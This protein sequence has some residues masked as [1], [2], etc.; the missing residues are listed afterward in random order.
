MLW[1]LA[2][3]HLIGAIIIHIV[4]KRGVFILELFLVGSYTPHNRVLDL[5]PLA[6]YIGWFVG[7][8]CACDMVGWVWHHSEVFAVLFH[9]VASTMFG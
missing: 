2:T 6:S 7:V 8:T 3:I 9:V 5:L 4:I 1:R